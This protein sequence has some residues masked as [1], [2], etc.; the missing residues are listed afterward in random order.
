MG[1]S[2]TTNQKTEIAK[3][4]LKTRILITI[5][6]DSGPYKI[7]MNDSIEE[8]TIAG[9]IYHST[10]VNVSPVATYPDNFSCFFK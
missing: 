3:S 4:A 10:L 5:S 7:L 9:N 1:K 8:I 2:L 6:L